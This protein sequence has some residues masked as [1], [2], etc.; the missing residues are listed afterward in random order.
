[1]TPDSSQ[2]SSTPRPRGPRKTCQPGKPIFYDP[3][4]KRW[5]RLRRIFDALALGGAVIGVLFVIGL[6]KMRPLHALDLRSATKRY[7]AL[8]NP[9]A[10]ELSPK[11]KL[12]HSV[13][14]HSDLKPSDVVLNQ[15]EGLRAAFY[16][17][18]DP[19]SYASFKEH[20]KQIDILFPEWLHVLGADGSLTAYSSD[21]TPFAVV[22]G[23]GIHG[24]DRENKV[25]KAITAAKEDTEIF[26]L[27][28]NYNALTNTFS[29]AVGPFL[30]SPTARANFVAEIDRLLATNTR[31]RGIVLS[32]QEVPSA[33]LPAYGALVETISDDFHAHN[34]KLYITVPVG[35]SGYDLAF[36][37]AHTDGLVLMNFGEH[38]NQTISGP[39]ASQDWFEINLKAAMKVVPREKLLC[40]I[41]NYGYDWTLPLPPAPPPTHSANH[42]PRLAPMPSALPQPETLDDVTAVTMISTQDAW[43][44]ASDAEA[45]IDLDDASLNPHFAYDDE[46]AQERHRV[47]YLDAV[48]AV[49]QMRVARALGLQTFALWRLG[50]EDASIWRVWDNPLAANVVSQLANVPP[51]Y[52]VDTEGDGDILRVTGLPQYGHRSAELD[53]DKTI[54]AQYLS[55][56]NEAMD[57][58][59]LPYTVSQY[60][61]PAQEG[62]HLL[63]RR[64]RSHLD[65]QDP[66]HP[67][68]AKR[69]RDLLHDR[70]GRP[71]QRQRHAARLP[72]RPRD[73]QSHLH[74]P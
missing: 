67:Q 51:G 1:M 44:R 35:N 46:D 36:L 5:K 6:L 70:R 63:R 28:N 72:R 43:Q 58:Y 27:V 65:S 52:D 10:P 18:V 41:G 4:R 11:E 47:W 2:P 73:R 19:A 74:P 62:R 42:S 61:Y 64:T 39:V 26:P 13:H 60:G 34:L 49:N 59:P 40:A 12:N 22:D 8:S 14:R 15:G 54:P 31:Y 66:R 30:S 9:P 56:V 68:A 50:F 45:K 25:V 24:I 29:S 48:S 55:I 7:R 53:D 69:Q 17:D 21:N 23:A 32:F 3:Q 57:S 37:A 16:N 33:A 20:V 38:Q 71:G